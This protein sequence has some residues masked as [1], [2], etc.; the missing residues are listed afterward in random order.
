MNDQKNLT[1]PL[2]LWCTCIVEELHRLGVDLLCLSPGSRST[3]L[4]LAA[5]RKLEVKKKVFYDERS[6]AFF[7]LG[8]AKAKN[9]PVAILTTSGSALGHLLPALIEAYEDGVPLIL[10]T[11]DRPYELQDIGAN[12]TTRQIGIFDSYTVASLNLPPPNSESSLPYLLSSLDFT[13]EKAKKASQPVHINCAF[14]KPLEW[15]EQTIFPP[16]ELKNWWGG[17][18]TYTQYTY[19][20]SML[21]KYDLQAFKTLLGTVKSGLILIGK[22]SQSERCEELEQLIESSPWPV[23]TDLRSGYPQKEY[24]HLLLPYSEYGKL[25]Q[26]EC[27]LH[28]GGTFIS[29]RVQDYLSKL[30]LK[31]YIQ[32]SK[33][34]RRRDPLCI[35]SRRYIVAPKQ[36]ASACLEVFA[37]QRTYESPHQV[38]IQNLQITEFSELSISKYLLEG[39]PKDWGFYVSNSLPVRHLDSLSTQKQLVE[40]NRGVSGIDGTIASAL[41]FAF[42]NEKPQ[43][44]LIGDLAFL[45]DMSSLQ[46]VA[47]QK[48][49]LI[50]VV[51]NNKGG[52]IFSF[53][54]VAKEEGVFQEFFTTPHE[55]SIEDICGSF[56]L[57]YFLTETL[58]E[59]SAV[60]RGLE[61]EPSST[62]I[63]VQVERSHTVASYQL[64]H[65]KLLKQF[66]VTY[67][68]L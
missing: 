30:S 39:I 13:I 55:E 50:I 62:V 42:G 22:L 34:E 12:Q 2:A 60:L 54:P 47:K 37:N 59:F 8:Y 53:L 6:A 15:Q 56:K 19:P 52:G 14:R 67:A 26:P 36:I 43:V 10:I 9:K 27:I 1:E 24:Y 3:P 38:T 18:E 5:A 58:E 23:W 32:V 63:E 44:L 29:Q 28:F 45:H 68:S 21:A 17:I 35:Q 25:I 16:D 33:E 4:V 41:G 65:E 64:I 46:L 31:H 49:P 66:T 57:A 20:E 7:A 11:A 61:T 40:V 51:I 48:T